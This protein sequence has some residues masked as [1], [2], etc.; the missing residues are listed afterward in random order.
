M[1]ANGDPLARIQTLLHFTDQRNLP[2]I[3]ESGGLWATARLR[4]A[5]VEF[6]PG[7]DE[8][9]LALDTR[10]GMDQYVHLCF[11]GAHP[12][13][14]RVVERDP[15]V[16]LR[17][18]QVDRT[19][20]YEPGVMFVPGVGYAHGV[21]PIPVA[22]AS[23]QG[24]IDFEVLYNWMDWSVPNIQTRRQAAELCEILVPGQVALAYIRNMPDA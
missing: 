8:A 22:E 1:T 9:S 16:Q 12:M 11:R 15:G 4:Q 18:L 3:S 21:R 5:G 17:Y 24:M 13:A 19:I 2:R 7:G 14:Y 20:V 10:A 6:F 23:T